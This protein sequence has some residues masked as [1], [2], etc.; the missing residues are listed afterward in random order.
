MAFFDA[1]KRRTLISLFSSLYLRDTLV[2][3][4]GSL[5]D[6]AFRISQRSSID[7]DFSMEGEFP[8]VDWLRAEC[9][10]ALKEAFRDD[11]YHVIDVTVSEK[12][13]EL[14]DDLKDFWGGYSISFKLVNDETYQRFQGDHERLRRNALRLTGD[15][16]TFKIDISKHECCDGKQSFDVDGHRVY[17]YSPEMAVAEKIRAICQQMPE[18]RNMVK[19]HRAE[20]A[21]DFL[22]IYAISQ[23]FLVNFDA[24]SFRELVRKVFEQKRVPMH[25]IGSI[26]DY[27]EDHRLGFVGVRD[28]VSMD[29]L[30]E[31]FDFYVDFLV[32][33]CRSL[34]SLWNV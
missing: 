5:L 27:R 8:S 33:E 26:S 22:D 29:Q 15:S 9:E 1:V 31:D 4:G 12:P 3:K 14:S 19:K 32:R 2:L 6:I 13:P 30:L 17:G 25:L 23:A 10:S 20:R 21:R 24:K 16:P 7:L 34:E 18:Y 11:R 28:T